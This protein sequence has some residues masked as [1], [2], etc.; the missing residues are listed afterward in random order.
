MNNKPK[1]ATPPHE[2]EALAALSSAVRTLA[3]ILI[4]RQRSDAAIIKR[5]TDQIVCGAHEQIERL[6]LE[7]IAPAAE[8]YTRS[9][10]EVTRRNG[11][12]PP[13]SEE[14]GAVTI[15][16]RGMPLS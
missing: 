8:A 13:I 14:P 11:W 10:N 4:D 15:P 2:K 7:S 16:D 6:R 9:V 3:D 12:T 5:L 1:S